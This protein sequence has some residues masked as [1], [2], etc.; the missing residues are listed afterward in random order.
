MIAVVTLMPA[1]HVKVLVLAVASV[2]MLDVAQL[3][4]THR[5]Q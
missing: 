3:F 4:S 2:V 1:S 5:A